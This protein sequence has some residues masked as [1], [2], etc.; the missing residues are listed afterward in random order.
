MDKRRRAFDGGVMD[1]MRAIVG[2]RGEPIKFAETRINWPRLRQGVCT[3]MLCVA[4][5]V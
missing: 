1:G 2:R 3:L 5:V 4:V